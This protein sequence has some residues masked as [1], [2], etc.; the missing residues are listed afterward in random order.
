MK[1]NVI[2]TTLIDITFYSD[3]KVKPYTC[4][5]G[6]IGISLGGSMCNVARKLADLSSEC[7]FYTLL[8][9]DKAQ[10]I[11]ENLPD[12]INVHADILDKPQPVFIQI[13]EEMMFCSIT[14][15]FFFE[16]SPVEE[17]ADLTVTDNEDLLDECEHVIFSGSIPE[18]KK[19]LIGLV[20]NES[21]CLDDYDSF[22]ACINDW[23]DWCEF[24]IIT[25]GDRGIVYYD[26][27]E[28]KQVDS[29][30][31]KLDHTLGCGDTFLAGF[32][33]SYA[34][35]KIIDDCVED[36]QRLVKNLYK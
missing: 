31:G 5:K 11:I 23:K 28:N 1:I 26:G 6:S 4:N 34:L 8:G 15:D 32:I 17:E 18:K 3:N 2:G 16:H 14:P 13:N 35:N 20:I 30:A 21:E 12:L 25:R 36:G 7:D 19:R 22:N 24:I 27:K 33:H 10:D 29:I 9:N